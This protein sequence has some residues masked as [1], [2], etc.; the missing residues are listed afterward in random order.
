MEVLVVMIIPELV[1]KTISK[2][3]AIINQTYEESNAQ[4]KE[5]MKQ[6]ALLYSKVLHDALDNQSPNLKLFY[7]ATS[8]NNVHVFSI[9]NNRVT[10]SIPRD[11]SY[12]M[13]HMDEATLRTHLMHYLNTSRQQKSLE[14]WNVYCA[15]KD[16]YLWELQSILYN[17]YWSQK[18]ES[19]LNN[20]KESL[21]KEFRDDV[22]FLWQTDI[23][24]IISKGDFIDIVVEFIDSGEE[25]YFCPNNSIWYDFN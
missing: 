19:A 4:Q 20:Y 23:V 6:C 13:T 21:W 2:G 18:E 25:L 12:M 3:V 22:A 15:Y 9:E 7:N 16:K 11:I 1:K 14:L 24:R 8:I 5:N 17:P 10:Y